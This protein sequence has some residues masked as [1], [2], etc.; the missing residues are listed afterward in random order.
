MCSKHQME[1]NF[2]WMLRK[3]AEKNE[4]NHEQNVQ[5]NM[6]FLSMGKRT[7]LI[8]QLGLKMIP[9]ASKRH[10]C[11]QNQLYVKKLTSVPNKDTP[12]KSKNETTIYRFGVCKT[13]S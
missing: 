13:N 12:V 1:K 2:N 9:I 5:Q 3:R 11:Q 8:P 6:A 7:K 4:Y 10:H